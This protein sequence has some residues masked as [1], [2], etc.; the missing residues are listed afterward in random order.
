MQ[1]AVSGLTFD[2]LA[3]IRLDNIRALPYN[4]CDN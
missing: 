3:Q 2:Y 1:I 4:Y